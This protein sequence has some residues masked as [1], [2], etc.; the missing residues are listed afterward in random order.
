ML[1]SIKK[2]NSNSKDFMTIWL[3]EGGAE[4]KQKVKERTVK[5]RTSISAIAKALLAAYAEYRLPED[6]EDLLNERN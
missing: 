1:K 2:N 6:L 4:L 5:D 3:G